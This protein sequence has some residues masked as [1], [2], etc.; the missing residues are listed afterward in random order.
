VE[1]IVKTSLDLLNA[2]DEGPVPEVN[3][4]RAQRQ[5]LPAVCRL[6]VAAHRP[7]QWVMPPAAFMIF[8]TELIDVEARRRSAEVLVAERGERIVGTITYQGAA[9]APWPGRWAIVRALAVDP[10]VHRQGVGGALIDSAVRC[11]LIDR[12]VALGVHTAGFM[13]GAIAL[14]QGRGFAPAPAYDVDLVAS[15]NLPSPTPLPLLAHAL[16]LG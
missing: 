13:T 6:L 7:Y 1:G 16:P 12:A 14:F 4:R 8:V 9:R 15:L 5:D 3:V 2:G 10:E 11:A